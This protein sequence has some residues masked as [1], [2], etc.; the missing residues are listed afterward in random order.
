MAQGLRAIIQHCR[1]TITETKSRI[2]SC[3][4]NTGLTGLLQTWETLSPLSHLYKSKGLSYIS[5]SVKL[6]FMTVKLQKHWIS[7]N[8]LER[9]KP[10]AAQLRFAKLHLT[11]G[12][13]ITNTPY[14]LSQRWKAEDGFVLQPHDLD[15]LYSPSQPNLNST[16]IQAQQ[17]TSNRTAEKEKNQCCNGQTS[18]QL[19]T[20]MNWSFVVKKTDPTFLPQCVTD[21]MI[22]SSNCCW[23]L[24]QQAALAEFCSFKCCLIWKFESQQLCRC[25]SPRLMS[26]ITEQSFFKGKEKHPPVWAT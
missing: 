13:Y 8:Y 1:L 14:K 16:R 9:G 7:R 23:P 3:V 22:A 2:Y 17:Q 15:T 4:K 12:C 5:A 20:S 10:L 6:E 19:Q 21:K 11:L 26:D 18:T 24:L 25:R